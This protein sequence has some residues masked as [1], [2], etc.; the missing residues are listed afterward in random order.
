MRCRWLRAA[1]DVA[2]NDLVVAPDIVTRWFDRKILVQSSVF[3]L[4]LSVVEFFGRNVCPDLRL[5]SSWTG[6]FQ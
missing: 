6:S 1:I 2:V 4:N 5:S 3:G